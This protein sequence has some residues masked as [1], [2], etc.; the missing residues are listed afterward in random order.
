HEVVGSIPGLAQ[1]VKDLVLLWLWCRLAAVAPTG[2]LAWEPPYA[3][4]V[5]LK[6]KKISLDKDEARDLDRPQVFVCLFVFSIYC[7]Y[8]ILFYFILFY[9]ILFYF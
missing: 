5:T 7:F 8:F 6:K 3:E 9:F 4:D 2:P 1:W